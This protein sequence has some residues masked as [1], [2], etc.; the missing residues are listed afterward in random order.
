MNFKVGDLVA[1]DNAIGRLWGIIIEFGEALARPSSPINAK[2]RWSNGWTDWYN[3]ARLIII[4]K[5][6]R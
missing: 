1:Y 6:Q 4:E 5:A 2:V 3:T